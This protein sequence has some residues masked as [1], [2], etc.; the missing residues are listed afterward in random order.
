MKHKKVVVI[1][2]AFNEEQSV[3]RV[4]RDIPTGLV[5]EVIVVNNNSTDETARHARMAGATVL[6]E[7]HQGYGR[8][9]LKGMQYVSTLPALP[10]IIVFLDAD[11]SDFPEE[12]PKL[13]QPVMEEDFDLVV[14]ARASG[15][16]ERGSMTP[17]QILGNWIAT[18]LLKLIYRVHFTDLGPFRAIKYEKLLALNMTDKS[19]GWTIEMQI[20]AAKMRLKTTEIPVRYRVRIGQSKVSG[21]LKGTLMAGYK[22]ITTIFKYAY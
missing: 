5:Q 15:N 1:I 6:D 18:K 22:I 12:M 7:P 4:L 8:A 20:K 3:G 16:R 10:D 11:Y 17:Q 21:T 13:L 2:P 14:G 9:C 19:Y